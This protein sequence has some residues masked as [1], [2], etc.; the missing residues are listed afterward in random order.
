L[1]DSNTGK[2]MNKELVLRLSKYKRLLYKLRAL[3]LERVFSNNLGDAIGVAPALVRKDFSMLNLPGNKRGG[4]S[5]DLLI[6][7]LDKLLGRYKPQEVIVAGCGRIGT[8]LMRYEEFAKEGIRILAGFDVA[9]ESIPNTKDIPIMHIREMGR[10]IEEKGVKVGILSVPDSVAAEV[11][12][13][14]TR[15]GIVGVLNFSSVDLK[16]STIGKNIEAGEPPRCIIHNVNIG[17][18]L[19]HLFYRVNIAAEGILE[20]SRDLTG[21]ETG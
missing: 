20:E 11:F 8:A 2:A 14:M 21:E 6:E 3:G 10:F 17:L 9:P 19:E 13:I 4:Y 15:H 5:I 18:E 12:D 1:P 7:R 16:C